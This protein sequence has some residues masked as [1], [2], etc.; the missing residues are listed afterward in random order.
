LV[1]VVLDEV[2]GGSVDMKGS[3]GIG[4][5]TCEEQD[6]EGCVYFDAEAMYWSV[7]SSE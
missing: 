1:G 5:G 6:D 4:K 2:G 7:L 3:G